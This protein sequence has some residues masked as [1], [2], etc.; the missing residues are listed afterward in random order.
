ICELKSTAEIGLFLSLHAKIVILEEI[1]SILE[2]CI[3]TSPFSNKSSGLRHNDSYGHP[4]PVECRE[5]VNYP[6]IVF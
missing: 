5:I 3:P 2:F 1:V 4:K 6:R